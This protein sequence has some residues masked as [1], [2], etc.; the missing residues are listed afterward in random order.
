M[1]RAWVEKGIVSL[2]F[3]TFL[4]VFVCPY[5]IDGQSWYEVNFCWFCECVRV[6]D[7][8]VQSDGLVAG[9]SFGSDFW[10]R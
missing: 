10:L 5:C 2:Y 8:V 3:V 9:F 6:C 1:G 4:F 7:M